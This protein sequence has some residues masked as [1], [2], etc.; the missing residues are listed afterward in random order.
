[1]PKEERDGMLTPRQEAFAAH[2]LSGKNQKEA[3]IAAGYSE[4][5]AKVTSTEIMRD[6]NFREK[7][8]ELAHSKGLTADYAVDKLK[9][10]IEAETVLLM[11]KEKDTPL[12]IPD[13]ATRAKGMDMYLKVMGAY[14]DPRMDINANMVATVVVRSTEELGL[15]PF[16]ADVIEGE[17]VE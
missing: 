3:A 15:D 7:L 1:M 14:P 11:G 17:V 6:P 10:L 16:S 5:R 4:K 8:R 12:A 13:G 2:L 9:G